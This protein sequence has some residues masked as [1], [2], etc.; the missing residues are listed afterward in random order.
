MSKEESSGEVG[1]QDGPALEAPAKDPNADIYENRGSKKIIRVVTVMAY[2][3]SVSFVGILLSAYYI[4]LWEPPNPRLIERGRLRADPQVEFLIGEPNLEEADHLKERNLLTENAPANRMYKSGPFLGRIAHDA[5]DGVSVGSDEA[6]Q[7]FSTS[8]R[9]ILNAIRLKLKYSL[10]KSLRDSQS[11][12]TSHLS[13]GATSSSESD[14]HSPLEA[15]GAKRMLLNPNGNSSKTPHGKVSAREN[16]VTGLYR[17]LTDF[18]SS[19]PV[20]DP[21]S[22]TPRSTTTSD[23]KPKQTGRFSRTLAEPIARNEA[24]HSGEETH[25]VGSHTIAVNESSGSRSNHDATM[26]WNSDSRGQSET[27]KRQ[28]GSADRRVIDNETR[29]DLVPPEV[30][31]PEDRPSL[32]NSVNCSGRNCPDDD[33]YCTSCRTERITRDRVSIDSSGGSRFDDLRLHQPPDD[34]AVK[35]TYAA[36]LPRNSEETQIEKMTARSTTI[37]NNQLEQ[38]DLS[39]TQQQ[40]GLW[41]ILTE[42]TD[43]EETTFVEFTS[44]P[45]VQDYRNNFTSIVNDGDDENVT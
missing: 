45:M 42:S 17:K 28:R 22:S 36:K 25:V 18:S 32:N 15:K 16:Q 44:M 27:T 30:A 40:R 1:P 34:P 43:V 41:E 2:L 5:P 13:H 26:R 11:N 33:E 3:F 14:D 8:Q 24:R 35:P 10:M 4:F 31:T 29:Q 37:D 38:L 23:A 9:E 6:S 20:A 7:G 19:S 21:L 12:Q 39:T